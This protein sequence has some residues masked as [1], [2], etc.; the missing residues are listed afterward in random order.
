[1]HIT[2]SPVDICDTVAPPRCKVHA[3]WLVHH[4]DLITLHPDD[5]AET[6]HLVPARWTARFV[7]EITGFQAP[8]SPPL[9]PLVPLVHPLLHLLSVLFDV[10]PRSFVHPFFCLRSGMTLSMSTFRGHRVR[11]TSAF[12]CSIQAAEFTMRLAMMLAPKCS[13]LVSSSTRVFTCRALFPRGNSEFLVRATAIART[14][15]S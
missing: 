10:C 14:I 12:P 13:T 15:R 6:C 2:E 9:H 3:A 5:G 7:A 4:D 1:M 11:R 8:Q